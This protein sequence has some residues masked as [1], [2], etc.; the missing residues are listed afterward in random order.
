MKE[1]AKDEDKDVRVICVDL[2]QTLPIPKLSISV[3]YYRYKLWM[4]NLCV[5]DLK[6]NKSNMFAWDEVTVGHGSI[7]I[8]NCLKKWTVNEYSAKDL[9]CLA[10]IVAAKTKPST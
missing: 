3:A 9:L 7:E 6:T 1:L 5:H 2:Q 4:Y 8:A 10:I